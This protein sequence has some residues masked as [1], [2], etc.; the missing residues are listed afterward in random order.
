[1]NSI[2]AWP[3]RCWRRP[4]GST[5]PACLLTCMVWPCAPAQLTAEVLDRARHQRGPVFGSH[6]AAVTPRWQPLTSDGAYGGRHS[7]SVAQWHAA[8]ESTSAPIHSRP[9]P[10]Y[11]GTACS[12]S[13]VPAQARG[14][15]RVRL[16][17][18]VRPYAAAGRPRNAHRVQRHPQPGRVEELRQA[19][20]ALRGKGRNRQNHGTSVRWGPAL[21]PS[22]HPGICGPRAPVA[23]RVVPRQLHATSRRE[24]PIPLPASDLNAWGP[25]PRPGRVRGPG[26]VAGQQEQEQ[27]RQLPGQAASA[28]GA[29]DG[30]RRPG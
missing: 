9:L 8:F 14:V 19:F 13:A 11:R 24:E 29:C 7:Y 22:S 15:P 26:A 10:R 2:H 17:P 18:E 28:L 27:P 4:S 3:G 21:A 30:R 6:P 23:S 25:L 16:A 5:P 1:M 20:Q 12:A